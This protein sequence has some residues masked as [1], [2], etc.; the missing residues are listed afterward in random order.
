MYLKSIELQGFKSFY[1]KMKFEFREGITA[2]VGPNGSGK[3]NIADAVRWV[4]G[5]QSA[6]QLRGAKMEDVIFSGTELRKPLGFAYVALTLDNSDHMI[7]IAYEEVTVARRVY[8]SGESEYLINGSQC[9]LRDVQELFF[10]TGIGK[11]GYSIIGQ[12]QV[13]L[14]LS[15]K[16]EDRREL[17]DEAAGISK[18]KKRKYQA[19]R[20]LEREQE[21]LARINDILAELERQV[22]PLKR[23]SETAKQYLI[24]RDEL[25]GVEINLFISQYDEEEAALQKTREN[26]KIAQEQFDASKADY[27]AIREE[28]E[29]TS[30]RVEEMEQQLSAKRDEL[31]QTRILLERIRGQIDVLKEQIAG[32][33]QSDSHLRDRIESLNHEKE[34]RLAQAKEAQESIESLE[35]ELSAAVIAAASARE[36]LD[37]AQE[38]VDAYSALKDQG[39]DQVLALLSGDSDTK[40]SLEKSYT[41][42]EQNRLRRQELLD[43]INDRE[44]T[45]K[46]LTEEANKQEKEVSALKSRLARY[47]ISNETAEE[48][49][50]EIEKTLDERR[51][52][53]RAKQE[54]LQRERLRLEQ[55]QNLIERYEGYGG[56]IRQVMNQKKRVPGIIGVVADVIDV[57]KRYETAIEVALGGS[58]QNIVVETEK[59][60]RDLIAFLKENHYGRATFL[61]LDSVKGSG[62]FPKKEAL[63]EN[64]ALG[65]ASS[66]VK[67]DAKYD[68]LVDHLLGRILVADTMEHALAIARKY[69]Y[70]LRIVTLE[71]EVLSPGGAITGGAYKNSGNLLARN[72]EVED[73]RR[74]IKKLEKETSAIGEDITQLKEQRKER[75]D[76]LEENGSACQELTMQIRVAQTELDQRNAQ[77]DHHRRMADETRKEYAVLE[78]EH[79]ALRE[80]IRALESRR[81]EQEQKNQTEN[82]KID[83]INRRLEELREVLAVSREKYTDAEKELF[84][85]EHTLNYTKES[86]KR[87]N[88]EAEHF[89][90]EAEVL[91]QTILENA[92]HK[93][94]REAQ[95]ILM[96]EQLETGGTQK[97]ALEAEADALTEKKNKV[98]LRQKDFFDKRE[99][100]SEQM[101]ALDKEVYR[102]SGQEEKSQA[103]LQGY[104]DHMWEEYELTYRR[105]KELMTETDL[106]QAQMKK[107]CGELRKAIHDLGSINIDAIKDYQEISER[108]ETMSVQRNDLI[109]AEEKLRAIIRELDDQMRAIF[110]EKFEDINR[111]FQNVFAEL[112]GGGE[113]R[114]ELQEDEDILDAGIM[115]IAQPP[116]KKLQ[117]LR[118]LSGGEKSLTAIALLF[119]ILNLKPSPFCLL[120]EIEAAL[121]DNNVTR[122]ADY[123]KKLSDTTQFI[124]IT[125]RRGTMTAADV[126]YGITMQEK[127][128]STMV[129]VNMIDDQLTQ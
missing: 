69:K 72:R 48:E 41:L 8:R 76:I 112:F 59:E 68:T 32:A 100:L 94:E 5:E 102:L 40:A 21:S 98:A 11:E 88:E 56:A 27:E 67:A 35:N 30:R 117:N 128:V 54:E 24:Y 123:L 74:R 29:E 107:R 46:R 31:E 15:S 16:P 90:E 71:G 53:L 4:L 3:S 92:E 79:D 85:R 114:L 42:L 115:I 106:T 18:F 2:I 73:I 87:L 103:A 96:Q 51:P 81:E 26:L 122:F 1:H 52:E 121:D 13:D 9:R 50:L 78:E 14:I 129:S 44:Q 108:Y 57:E 105:A 61:P 64:G 111:S 12:G 127:G 65:T 93:E 7:P 89:G 101:N 55:V 118:M 20:S 33:E 84:A 109:E 38:K 110:A 37:A 39:Y 10:D 86:V 25:K 91:A 47:E 62:G 83:E 104:S 124:V 97:A 34:T 99:A 126:L 63:R 125:H 80:E 23:Q 36:E 58:I 75:F 120:D 70:S 60:A 66:L 17:F 22:G 113:A 45:M 43:K 95:L 119:A 19:E 77:V 82:E 49:R 116:G 6:K 28:Y